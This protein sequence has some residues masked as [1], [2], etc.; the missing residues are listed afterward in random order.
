MAS[1]RGEALALDYGVMQL[2]FTAH[3]LQA[4]TNI[5]KRTS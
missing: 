2:G 4:A 3:A 1:V 5:G